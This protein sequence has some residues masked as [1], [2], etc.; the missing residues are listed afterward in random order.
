MA[1][2]TGAVR[3]KTG[4]I[5]KWFRGADAWL[6]LLVLLI[7]IGV[8]VGTMSPT[9]DF[10]DC[11]EFVA[12]SHIVGVPHQPGTPLY[13]LV[14]RLF[15][16]LF[17]QS[18]I[19]QPSYTAAW[20]VN[21]MSAA[22]SAMAVMLVF[23]II[24]RVAR[25]ADPDNSRLARVGGLVG[26]LFLLFSETFWSNA[27][28]AEVYGLAA[29]TM[30]LLTWLALVW[31]DHRHA[32]RSD[33][34]LLLLIYLCGLGVGFH[35]GSLLVFPAFF[36]MVWLAN[37]RRLPMLDL[38]LASAGL[39][40][41]LA[42]TTFIKDAKV[43]TVLLILYAAACGLRMFW[44]ALRRPAGRPA[45]EPP[46]LIPFAL[47]G[48][49][50]FGAGLSVHGVLMIRAG[51]EPEPAIN[52][53]VPA[54]F[55]TFKSVL[56]REQYPP[57][58]PLERK[59]PLSFQSDYYYDFLLRQFSF[60]PQAA[61][62]LDRISVLV[63]PLLLALLGAAHI[64]RRARPLAWLLVLGY[65]I[66][67][68]GLT[69]Y[70]NFTA[71]E[72]RE[73]D[74]FYFAAFL[75][76]A[77]FVGLGT[78]ALLRWTSGPLGPTQADL[79]RQTAALWA[80]RRAFCRAGAVYQIIT[81]FAVAL[82]LTAM[83]PAVVKVRWLGLFLFGGI[84]AGLAVAPRLSRL[85]QPATGKSGK[86]QAWSD[87]SVR[88]RL[89]TGLGLAC[90]TAF[91]GWLL[92]QLA[93][94]PDRIFAVGL[95]LALVGGQL[96]HY[97][98]RRHIAEPEPPPPPPPPPARLDRL[99]WIAG[100]VLVILAALPA[101][102]SLDPG[103]HQKWFRH[104]RSEN[105]LAHEYA[106]NIL[107]GMD[108]DAILFTNGDNDTF[109]IWFLQEVEHFRR[110]VTVVNLSLVNL[111]WYIK[112]LRRLSQPLEL[113]FTDAHIDRLRPQA[114]RDRET[115][116]L[117]VMYV[118]DF[119]VRDV[120]ETNRKRKAPRPIYFAVTIPRENMEHYYSALQMEGLVYRLTETRSPDGLPATDPDRLLAN[121]FGAYRFDALTDGD[122]ARRHA[123]YA[124]QAGWQT[125]RPPHEILSELRE[126]PPVDYEQLLPLLGHD[127]TD[128]YRDPNTAN[129]L[130]NYPASIS[131]A[132]FTYLTK[133]E[134]LRQR[135][136]TI[137]SADTGLYDYYTDR[138]LLS[139]ET[140]LR[141]D[142]YNIL[143]AA[144]YYPA[145]LLERGRVDSALA[146]LEGIHGR[147]GDDVEME[148]LRVTIRGLMTMDLTPVAAAW[149]DRRLDLLPS[150]RP[151]YELLFRLYEAA[152]AISEAAAVADR[153]RAV[154]GFE[155][156]A[157]NRQLEIMR[158]Q[159]RRQEQERIQQKIHESGI[160][161]EGP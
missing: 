8:Y 20:A 46:R 14:G 123:A 52:Q 107:A 59:A 81:A 68:E 30:A 3:E 28:E 37:D 114:Y 31:Y 36:V 42:S 100:G 76:A 66:N 65:L 122:T 140:T 56:R 132:G 102:G 61:R 44:P 18:D 24:V 35:L 87:R 144:G 74:Y 25:R 47:L 67:A 93:A 97:G 4:V 7:A 159:A 19:A 29:F 92:M 58:N 73:R 133:A 147:V 54:D 160:L 128:I 70:L 17:G 115:G 39:A 106:S 142:P 40:L 109:P 63:G 27:I 145:L 53:T 9:I 127:R 157:L 34:I 41:F 38:L 13:V 139:Y 84:F 60:L 121:V 69:I 138:A 125:D 10:W 153:W 108:R 49:L 119:V 143:V 148:A 1:N 104:N 111:P 126:P 134:E 77:I 101:I 83:T 57:L 105:R 55:Q 32:R 150:W 156:P 2:R 137:A 43:L 64:L 62:S 135:D 131:R 91:G 11:G 118:R 88:W 72:V 141:F 85:G 89:A 130:G 48:L 22:F 161:P 154:T 136:G 33:W 129:L 99:S 51:A 151:G 15:I 158:E 45:G 21:F 16:I 6:S 79:E 117:V 82:I 113:S 149:L 50:L 95:Y 146:Y 98:E 5:R 90:G 152:G 71:N 80:P 103:A 94:P 26:A 86:P 12:V 116:E 124:A 155:D 23:L 78:A 112:Q 110:D 75:Y 120:I 96:L